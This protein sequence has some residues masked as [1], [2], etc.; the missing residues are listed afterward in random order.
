MEN[1]GHFWVE[2]NSTGL[3]YRYRH[4]EGCGYGAKSAVG[5][6]HCHCRSI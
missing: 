2:I 1:L 6:D 4:P 3:F 5:V